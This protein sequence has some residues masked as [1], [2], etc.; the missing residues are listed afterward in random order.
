MT[1]LATHQTSLILAFWHRAKMAS[2]AGKQ[3]NDTDGGSGGL[4]LS[5]CRHHLLPTRGGSGGTF[6]ASRSV[7]KRRRL[8]QQQQQQ[9]G[10]QSQAA[11]DEADGSVGANPTDRSAAANTVDGGDS[12]GGAYTGPFRVLLTTYK[13]PSSTDTADASSG[14]SKDIQNRKAAAAAG[15]ARLLSSVAMDLAHSLA[16]QSSSSSASSASRPPCRG[17]GASN[18]TSNTRNRPCQCID[19]VYILYEAASS[20]GGGSAGGDQTLAA[21]G[22]KEHGGDDVEEDLGADLFPLRCRRVDNCNDTDD[23]EDSTD[24]A[25]NSRP[26]SSQP[27]SPSW[28]EGAL[29]RIQIR[30]MRDGTDLVRYLATVPLLPPHQQPRKGIVLNDIGSFVL[31][32][33]SNGNGGGGGGTVSSNSTQSVASGPY[34]SPSSSLGAPYYTIDSSIVLTQIRKSKYVCIWFVG[35]SINTPSQFLHYLCFQCFAHHIVDNE[36]DPFHPYKCSVHT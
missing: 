27:S 5:A 11:G 10:V 7:G 6:A 35:W 20:A 30:R 12:G 29:S 22:G 25:T 2:I 4:L 24:P 28:D 34:P 23:A 16:L 19:V 21:G 18:G 15:N 33:T 13:T 1:R 17:C 32:N 26:P 9:H 3:M 8:E 31:G 14:S 36:T